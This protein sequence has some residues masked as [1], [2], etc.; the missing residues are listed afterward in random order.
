VN[1]LPA[2]LGKPYRERELLM[3]QAGS[4]NELMLRQGDWK[5]V[6][7]S[8]NKVTQRDVIGLYN[9]KADPQEKNNLV[10]E[11][12]QQARTDAMNKLYW[13]IRESGRRTAPVL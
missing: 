8:N 5:L 3:Q 6:I 2:L 4:K 11:P 9:L 10:N 12:E 13:E 1:I 7:Q